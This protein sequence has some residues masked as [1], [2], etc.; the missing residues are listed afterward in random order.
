MEQLTLT[1]QPTYMGK[2]QTLINVFGN[3]N[4]L[5]DNFFDYH[6]NRLKREI[7]RMQF[8]LQ[9]YEIKYNMTSKEFYRKLENGEVGD[10][11]DFVMWSGIYELL[12]DS[13]KQLSQLI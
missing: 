13:K 6:T 3:N 12:L 2:M 9:K 11:R 1:L 10:D 4:L 7:G 5:I 8:A